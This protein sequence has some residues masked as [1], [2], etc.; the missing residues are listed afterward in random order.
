MRKIGIAVVGFGNIGKS[1]VKAV[2]DANDMELQ[3]VVEMGACLEE[4]R[5]QLPGVPFEDDINKLDNVDIAV[6]CL[7][8]LLVPEMAATILQAGISSVDC[9]DIHGTELLALKKNL[10]EASI[11]NNVVSISA[12][13]WDPGTDSVIR[14]IFEVISPQGITYTNFGPG[15]SM[16]HTVAA[17]AILGVKKALSITVP[18]GFGFHKRCVYIEQEPGYDFKEISRNIKSDKYFVHD[19][20]HVIPSNDIDL[21]ADNGHSVVLERKGSAS[22]ASNQ[23]MTFQATV[24]NPAVTAQIMICSARAAMRQKPG[25]YLLIEIPPIDLLEFSDK[26]VLIKRIV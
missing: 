4:G 19:E 24:T 3:G 22:Q 23:R 18:S 15:M 9:Y 1:A 21:L 10:H 2:E 14:A 5:K 7:P 6:L 8:S 16:G 11:A 12:A 26:D 20:T 25:N 13:G 17:K